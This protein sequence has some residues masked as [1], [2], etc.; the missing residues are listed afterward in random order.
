MHLLSRPTVWDVF[1][2]SPEHTDV[3]WLDYPAAREVLRF[4]SKRT[5]LGELRERLLA[6][7]LPAPV[8]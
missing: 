8:N 5:A 6:A 2:F 1:G 7:D 4:D 3:Q